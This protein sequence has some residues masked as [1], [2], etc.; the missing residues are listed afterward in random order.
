MAASPEK[1]GCISTSFL[2]CDVQ[3]VQETFN[4]QVLAELLVKGP[5]A[6]F[7]KTLV[8]PGIGA[9]LAPTTGYESQTRDTFFSVGLQGVNPND[10]TKIKKIIEETFQDVVQTGFPKERVEAVLHGIELGV[11]HQNANFGLSVLF[12]ISSLWNHDGDILAALGIEK[13]IAQFRESLK[14]DEKYLQKK[15][16]I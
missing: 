8:E 14:K 9:G 6:A 10:F 3:D 16:C 5:N 12:G 4:L 13:Q 7:Y 11:K 2:C 1:Q 15:V